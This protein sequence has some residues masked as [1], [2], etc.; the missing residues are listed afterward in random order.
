[1]P[2]ADVSKKNMVSFLELLLRA[3]LWTPVAV[4]LFLSLLISSLALLFAPLLGAVYF[5]AGDWMAGTLWTMAAIAA[6]FIA[7]FLQKALLGKSPFLAVI[8]RMRE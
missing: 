7:R 8:W 3:T 2:E 4:I 6:F 5:Y 1:M